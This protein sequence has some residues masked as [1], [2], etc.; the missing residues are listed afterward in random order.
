[1]SCG[2]EV[3]SAVADFFSRLVIVS[4]RGFV[5]RRVK[6]HPKVHIINQAV[7]SSLSEQLTPGYAIDGSSADVCLDPAL[8]HFPRQFIGDFEILNDATAHGLLELRWKG[9]L[10]FGG[11][12]DGAFKRGRRVFQASEL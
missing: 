1:M 11:G 3:L 6:A 10:E 5:A 2:N 4:V 12:I 8:H 9:R 7:F